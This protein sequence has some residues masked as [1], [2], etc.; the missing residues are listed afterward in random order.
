[1]RGGAVRRPLQYLLSIRTAYQLVHTA[2]P[3][4]R[5]SSANPNSTSRASARLNSPMCWYRLGRSFA[6]T[7][8]LR[9]EEVLAELLERLAAMG[10]E[11]I[12]ALDRVPDL[13]EKRRIV[14]DP[15]TDV[16]ATAPTAAVEGAG[17]A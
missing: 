6:S 3:L 16:A 10:I 5:S 13:V 8:R 1:M 11:P 4:R 9:R 15:A 2:Y 12:G 14:H 7:W 17:V